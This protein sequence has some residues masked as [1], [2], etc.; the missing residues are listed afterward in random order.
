LSNWIK[1]HYDPAINKIWKYEFLYLLFD[2]AAERALIRNM[3]IWIEKSD[4]K[5]DWYIL[6]ESAEWWDENYDYN[7]FGFDVGIDEIQKYE[8]IFQI[9]F[10]NEKSKDF[11]LIQYI[12]DE[13]TITADF[14]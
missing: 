8:K 6:S 7:K 3:V 14:H 11:D 4:E 2:I 9:L 5:N 13:F 12:D 10:K 1:W